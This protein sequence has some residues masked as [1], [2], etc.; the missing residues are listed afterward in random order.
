[1]LL[2]EYT[3][4]T[5]IEARLLALKNPEKAVE[6]QHET[7]RAIV[8]PTPG[9]IRIPFVARVEKGDFCNFMDVLVEDL[10]H[11]TVRFVAVDSPTPDPL[12]RML[13]V[14]S[15]ED[16]RSLSDAVNGFEREEINEYGQP[17]ETLVGAWTPDNR[18]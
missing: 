2:M 15:P 13:D 11:E 1:M 18:P 14:M 16:A 5:P 4:I 7:C 8:E 3:N 9:E 6:A 17:V 10:G 12:E